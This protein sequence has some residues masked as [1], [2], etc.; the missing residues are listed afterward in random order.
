[1]RK[2]LWMPV[3]AGP[4][5]RGGAAGLTGTG[6]AS[7]GLSD[8]LQRSVLAHTSLHLHRPLLLPSL[9]P[10]PSWSG[11]PL[12]RVPRTLTHCGL[13]A[14]GTS[15]RMWGTQEQDSGR[16][17][18]PSLQQAAATDTRTPGAGLSS[19]GAQLLVTEPKPPGCPARAQQCGVQVLVGDWTLRKGRW[20]RPA[21]GLSGRRPPSWGCSAPIFF[22]APVTLHVTMA[23]LLPRAPTTSI[24]PN[25]TRLRL[26]ARS[27]AV[28]SQ[29][30]LAGAC[31][32]PPPPAQRVTCPPH[33]LM[34]GVSLIKHTLNLANT[35]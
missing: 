3:S 7:E 28:Q 11:Q 32:A 24:L 12:T 22:P 9:F 13:S 14:A 34:P 18:G 15:G 4:R 19:L 16:P 2:F 30:R 5:G 31:G 21:P 26:V 33:S 29:L 17:S 25:S 8:R 6:P 20:P 23:L 1:M 27:L 35:S 10:R